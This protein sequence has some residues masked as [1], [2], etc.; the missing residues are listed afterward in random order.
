MNRYEIRLSA[1]FDYPNLIFVTSMSY[2]LTIFNWLGV[3]LFRNL[4]SQTLSFIHTTLQYVMQ[5][6]TQMICNTEVLTLIVQQTVHILFPQLFHG[7]A[8]YIRCMQL[9]Y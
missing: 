8:N 1:G 7:V 5:H 3:G 4:H 6:V 2:D 9:L